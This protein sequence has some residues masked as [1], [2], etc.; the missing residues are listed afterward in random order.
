MQLNKYIIVNVI[1]INLY[2]YICIKVNCLIKY[3]TNIFPNLVKFK[4]LDTSY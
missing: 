2:L 1:K 3:L 4:H